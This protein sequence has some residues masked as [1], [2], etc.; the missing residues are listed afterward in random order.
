MTAGI[1]RDANAKCVAKILSPLFFFFLF[2]F[3]IPLFSLQRVRITLQLFAAAV[4]TLQYYNETRS[5]TAISE[6]HGTRRTVRERVNIPIV[7]C[8]RSLFLLFFRS[9]PVYFVFVAN[10]VGRV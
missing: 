10:R 8:S 2:L 5:R 6:T 1:E 7:L 3:S 9:I 4:L